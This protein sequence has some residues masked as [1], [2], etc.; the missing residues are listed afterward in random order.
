[1]ARNGRLDRFLRVREEFVKASIAL[2][3]YNISIQDGF[4]D[5]EIDR[6]SR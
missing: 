2:S 1:M 6:A 3:A 4:T 5:A